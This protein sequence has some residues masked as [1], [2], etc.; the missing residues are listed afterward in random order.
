MCTSL[1]YCKKLYYVHSILEGEYRPGFFDGVAAVVT[2][3][4]N[5]SNPDQLYFGEKD[6]QQLQVV[7][8]IVRDLKMGVTV[9][10]VRTRREENGLA[11]SSRNSYLTEDQRSVAGGIY[12]VLLYISKELIGGNKNYLT[13]E[14]KGKREIKALGMEPQ[15]LSIRLPNLEFPTGDV[16]ISNLREKM[17]KYS[18]VILVAAFLGTTRL[19]DNLV[20][21]I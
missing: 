19:I 13:L 4:I 1:A 17:Q 16:S 12:K 8:Q 21:Q 7:K 6:W 18:L 11:M 20:V 15:Y 3:L 9:F 10:G 14:E 2:I 5:L